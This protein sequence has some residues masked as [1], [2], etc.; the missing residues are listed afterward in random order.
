[1]ADR[2]RVSLILTISANAYMNFS[3]DGEVLMISLEALTIARR[4]LIASPP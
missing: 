1:M 2:M 3:Q 4:A